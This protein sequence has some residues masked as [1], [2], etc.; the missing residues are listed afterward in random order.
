MKNPELA[1]QEDERKVQRRKIIRN[2]V[3]HNKF[4]TDAL[5]SGGPLSSEKQPVVLPEQSEST[6]NPMD[7]PSAEQV[8][9][10]E[11]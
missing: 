8:A 3:P 4:G 11:K 7:E 6:P 2:H 5:E 10:K 9:L 1:R